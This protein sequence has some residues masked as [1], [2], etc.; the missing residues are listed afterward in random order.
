M[1]II[2]WAKNS[3]H[4]KVE[5]VLNG[6]VQQMTSLNT[7]TLKTLLKWPRPASAT[8]PGL[9]Q[10]L[11]FQPQ[12]PHETRGLKYVRKIFIG[13]SF[14][15]V[16]SLGGYKRIEKRVRGEEVVTERFGGCGKVRFD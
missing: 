9:A 15:L 3:I 4:D 14:P 7:L 12:L 11:H 8:A 5:A 6:L 16:K 1:L 10:S 2:P 13:C